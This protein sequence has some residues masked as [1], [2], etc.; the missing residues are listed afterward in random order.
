M[1]ILLCKMFSFLILLQLFSVGFPA[2]IRPK[3]QKREGTADGKLDDFF[4]DLKNP[5]RNETAQYLDFKIPVVNIETWD[6]TSSRKY[7]KIIKLRPVFNEEFAARGAKLTTDYILAESIANDVTDKIYNHTLKGSHAPKYLKKAWRQLKKELRKEKKRNRA[8][9]VFNDIPDDEQK[10]FWTLCAILQKW[11]NPARMFKSAFA[12]P[13]KFFRVCC[14]YSILHKGKEFSRNEKKG[15]KGLK[16]RTSSDVIDNLTA[17]KMVKPS[18]RYHTKFRVGAVD[19]IID[20]NNDFAI[21]REAFLDYIPPEE[22]TYLIEQEKQAYAINTLVNIDVEQLT[23]SDA[24]H[25]TTIVIDLFGEYEGVPAIAFETEIKSGYEADTEPA[26]V[27]TNTG[28]DSLDTSVN[29]VQ[30]CKLMHK[31]SVS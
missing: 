27:L 16:E 23:Y 29:F 9:L 13:P 12:K 25:T 15:K 31:S 28:Y 18:R 26:T 5:E 17:E 22:I 1:G 21:K 11:K 19:D 8:V 30:Q 10:K 3:K 20:L 2:S 6:K 7:N 24:K 14:A 4:S